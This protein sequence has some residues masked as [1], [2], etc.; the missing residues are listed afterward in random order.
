MAHHRHKIS[1]I[2]MPLMLVELVTGIIL[3]V[4]QWSSLAEFHILNLM[5][6]AIIW[7]HTFAL[8]VPFHQTF[9]TNFDLDLLNRM[10]KHHWLRTTAWSIK[11][12]LW[13]ATLWHILTI[14]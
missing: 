3:A 4:F 1:L 14:Y 6:I 8:M 13:I 11:S 2:V 12:I 10:L 9:E 5:L 7:I